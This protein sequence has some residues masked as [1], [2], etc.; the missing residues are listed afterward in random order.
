MSALED[1]PL[2]TQ[3]RDKDI[4]R[5]LELSCRMNGIPHTAL[6]VSRKVRSECRLMQDGVAITINPESIE[7]LAF[8]HEGEAGTEEGTGTGEALSLGIADLMVVSHYVG[9]ARDFLDPGF[10]IE[11]T[12][13]AARPAYVRRFFNARIDDLAV[14]ARLRRIPLLE[15]HFKAYATRTVDHAMAGLPTHMQLLSLLRAYLFDVPVGEASPK[16]LEALGSPSAKSALYTEMATALE[17]HRL[18]YAERHRI[19][20]E[21][22]F[23]VYLDLFDYDQENSVSNRVMK[24]YE[25]ISL[26]EDVNTVEGP[27]IPSSQDRDAKRRAEALFNALCTFD[28]DPGDKKDADAQDTLAYQLLPSSGEARNG[29]ALSNKAISDYAVRVRQL[30]GLI[31]ETAETLTLLS[32]SAESMTIPR[33]RH[34]VSYEGSRFSSSALENASLQLETG[35]SLPIWQPV[36]KRVRFQAHQFNGF[37][38]YL[39]LD[40]SSSMSGK[41]AK[42]ATDMSIC[43]IEGVQL[44]RYRA[45]LEAKKGSVRVRTQLIAF[46]AG[47][48]ELTPL[49]GL[50]SPEQKARACYNLLNPESD[51]TSISGALH[52]VQSRVLEGRNRQALCLIVSDGMFS[53][54]MAAYRAVQG[55]PSNTYI[56]QIKIGE[57]AGMPITPHYE[58]VSDP[59]ALPGKLLSILK[60]LLDRQSVVNGGRRDPAA[61]L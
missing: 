41:S 1:G 2:D 26:L 45:E 47:W 36:E 31:E 22:L 3:A 20:D 39:L 29:I 54:S 6:T 7:T 35:R 30:G 44:A 42:Y 16:V 5:L 43:L 53:D 34:R 32:L 4:K 27:I 15:R 52:Y 18:P 60:E 14:D 28:E 37:D 17:D 8:P 24:I 48:A 19:A 33:Y 38:V 58:S 51:Q 49:S 55:M 50:L 56:G 11:I 21:L 57:F 40:V 46:G 10:S 9:R 13:D 61:L 23:P 59:Q 25:S 12:A